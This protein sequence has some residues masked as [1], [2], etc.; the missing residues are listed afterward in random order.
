MNFLERVDE[1][2]DEQYKS[3]KELAIEAK[4]SA[5]NISKG[6]KDGNIP[7]ADTAVRIARV[8]G[9]TVE[10]L[11]YGEDFYKS[12]SKSAEL[13]KDLS[14]FRKYRELVKSINDL[15]PKSQ[16]AVI[17]LIEDMKGL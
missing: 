9:V 7:A 1:L 13:D 16:N 3:G 4:F 6:K 12:D 14:L 2:L 10:Y 11:V 15:S 5:S 8:L 17:H